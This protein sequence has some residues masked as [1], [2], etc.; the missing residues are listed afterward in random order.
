MGGT[1]IPIQKFDS[2]IVAVASPTPFARLELGNTSAGMHQA[3]G[4]Y[5]QAYPRMYISSCNQY[6]KFLV[7][8]A[9]EYLHMS[10]TPNHPMPL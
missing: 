6:G 4:P 7:K 2:H 10:A 9:M 5:E 1:A 3:S 8:S